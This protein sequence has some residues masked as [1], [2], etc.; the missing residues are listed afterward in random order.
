MVINNNMA[1]TVKLDAS[2]PN[3]IA[4]DIVSRGFGVG[5]LTGGVRK[6]AVGFTLKTGVEGQRWYLMSNPADASQLAA[7]TSVC[8]AQPVLGVDEAGQQRLGTGCT[9]GAIE[10]PA[11]TAIGSTAVGCSLSP[12]GSGRQ[13]AGLGGLILGLGLT[14]GLGALRRSR[15]QQSSRSAD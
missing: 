11:G 6:G 3:L 2:L 10:L 5:Q 1:E 4:T 7:D 15:R 13:S 9:L 8:L 12:G 14:L